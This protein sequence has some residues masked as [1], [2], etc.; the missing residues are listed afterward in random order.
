MVVQTKNVYADFYPGPF[1][2][3]KTFVFSDNLNWRSIDNVPVAGAAGTHSGTV[4]VLR[5]ADRKDAVF[6]KGIEVLEYEAT[7]A[8]NAVNYGGKHLGAGQ[9]TARGVF[10]LNDQQK[11]PPPPLNEKRF[12]I[13]GGTGPYACARGEGLETPTDRILE[14]DL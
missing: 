5:I 11:S 3:G 14:I 10:Y 6:A 7:W 8:L 9:V 13:T 2:P 12:A 1:G 4:R